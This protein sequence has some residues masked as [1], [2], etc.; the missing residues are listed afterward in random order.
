MYHGI[1]HSAISYF[2]ICSMF[3]YRF[4]NPTKWLHVKKELTELLWILKLKSSLYAHYYILD[5]FNPSLG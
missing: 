3:T 5:C 4:S 1:T 2:T